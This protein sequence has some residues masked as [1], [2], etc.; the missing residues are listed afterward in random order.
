MTHQKLDEK[1]DTG[2]KTLQRTS[3]FNFLKWGEYM[4]RAQLAERK[5]QKLKELML[6][7]DPVV[8]GVVVGPTQIAQWNEFIKEFPDEGEQKKFGVGNHEK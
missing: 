7:T 6:L 8:S 2:Y 1:K 5:V 4:K 3:A